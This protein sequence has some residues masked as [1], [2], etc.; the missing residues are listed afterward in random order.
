M[1]ALRFSHPE[2]L[3]LFLLVPAALAFARRRMVGTG[4]LVLRTMVLVMAVLSLASPQISRSGTGQNVIFALDASES[5]SPAARADAVD[6][7]HAAAARRRPVD[8]I[9]AVTFAADAVVEEAPSDAPALAFTARPAP[10]AT[11]IAQAIRTALA[12]MPSG[13]ARRV[14]L[15]TDG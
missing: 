12:T 8:R 10:G 7:I 6:F 11:D 14:V 3:L 9:G 15:A 2:A 5:I 4:P 1:S 13:G